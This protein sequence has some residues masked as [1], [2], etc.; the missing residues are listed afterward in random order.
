MTPLLF[1]ME[2]RDPDDALTLAL[3]ADHPQVNLVGVTVNPGSQAQ[4]GVVRE[5]LRRCGRE[6]IPLG[7]RNPDHQG[8]SV[9][10]FHYRWLGDIEPWRCPTPAS[11][12]ISQTA[13]SHPQLVLLTGAPL[14]NLRLTL[15]AHPDLHLQRWVAQG[16]FAGDNLVAPEHR[17]EKFAG[18]LT[19]E[20]YNFGN[21][22]KGAE[23]ALGAPGFDRRELVSKNVTH[24]VP[25]DA[26]FHARMQQFAG[27]RLGVD[28]AIEMMAQY[29]SLHPEGKLLHDPLAAAAV[30][31]P[32]LFQWV[33]VEAYRQ[34]GAWG[35]RPAA[36]TNTFITT[37]WAQDQTDRLPS[38]LA[39]AQGR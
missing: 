21:D 2:T 31:E 8:E 24:G 10:E 18:R 1:D 4:L 19:C 28:Q 27:L 11:Q 17:L 15:R 23:L 30:V 37:Q 3:L 6:H 36:G 16:G 39:G 38:I 33:E 25:W 26:S 29:L 32:S 9:S 20:T 12:L 13:S 35:A 14:H 5:I 22:P 7:A 34:K